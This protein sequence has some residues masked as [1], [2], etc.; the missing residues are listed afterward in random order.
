MQITGLLAPLVTLIEQYILSKDVIHLDETTLKV[1]GEANRKNT[2]TSYIWLRVYDGPDPPAVSYRYFAS[3][4]NEAAEELL[5]GYSGMIQTDAYG[6]YKSVVK[7]SGGGLQQAF[8]LA[9]ARRKY[10]DIYV[11]CGGK[12]KKDKQTKSHNALRKATGVILEDIASIF[13]LESE[14]REQL[15]AQKITEQEFLARR[16]QRAKPLFEQ[17]KAHVD[18]NKKTV[19]PKTPF[20]GALNYTL[21]QWD[22]LQLYLE[23]PLLSPSNNSA[24]RQVRP[25]ALGRKNWNASGSP[26]G[27]KSSCAMYTI[28]QTAVQN[29][30]DPGAYL[31]HVLDVVTPLA[32]LPYK[33]HEDRWKKLLPWEIDPE[34]LAWPNRMHQT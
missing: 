11:G 9:H 25:V 8:C 21:N 33:D 5:E 4:G 22:G 24:E 28:L 19:I 18:A 12:S 15:Y 3:R 29:K 10:Y 27:A 7:S 2:T 17:L 1:M 14:L 30:L 32:D 26:A 34:T 31:S 6:V 23:T 13:K 16:K 20:D